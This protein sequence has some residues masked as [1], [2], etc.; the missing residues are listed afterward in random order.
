ADPSVVDDPITTADALSPLLGVSRTDLLP[1]L[2]PHKRDDGTDVLFEYL[3]RGVTV[4][5]GDQI[6][7]LGLHGIGV[8]RD[9]MRVVKSDL[10]ANLIGFTGWDLQGQA[11]IEASYNDVLRG[12][13]GKRTYEIGQ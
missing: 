7:A 13:D 11:G 5:M 4:A 1:K 8:R 6:E 10:A 9:Q 3:A 2:L 12:V